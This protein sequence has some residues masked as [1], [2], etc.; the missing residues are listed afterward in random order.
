VLVVGAGVAGLTA[1]GLLAAKGRRVLVLEARD[2]AGGRIDTRREAGWPLSFEGGAEF[3]HGRPDA[4]VRL[5]RAASARL[6][7]H[8]PR[9]VEGDGRRLHAA[10]ARWREAME[11]LEALP[12]VPPDL[13]Y[14]RLRRKPAWR[15]RAGPEVQRLALEFVQGF[16]AAPAGRLSA[17]SL[18]RQTQAA[19]EVEGDRLF[20]VEGGYDRIVGALVQRLARAGGELRLGARVRRLEWRG[21]VQAH[22]TGPLGALPPVR[23]RAAIVT[24]PV[25]VLRAGDVTFSPRLP[26]AKSAALAAME[27][28]PVVRVVL[29]FRRLPPPMQRRRINFLHVPRGALPTFWTVSEHDRQV[30]VGWAA[31][32]AVAELPATDTGR[33]AAAIDSLALG[34]LLPRAQVASALEGWRIFDWGA[35]PLARGAYTF[36]LPGAFDAPA[37]LAAPVGDTLFFAGEATH[38]GGAS[39]TV[40]GAI[41]TGQRAAREVLARG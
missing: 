21:R 2:R 23:A 1:A 14:D 7:E 31:G 4:I 13:S 20:R 25:G 5:C 16:N 37:R 33:L 39:G 27:M 26:A 3:V 41:E 36:C 19:A 34:L 17:V 22:A 40:H 6:I 29:R 12:L 30:L 38:A 32:P 24:L 10:G 28:G 9:H 11:L 18:G 15:R 8:V 35:D